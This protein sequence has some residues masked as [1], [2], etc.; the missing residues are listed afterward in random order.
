[1]KQLTELHLGSSMEKSDGDNNI[2]TVDRFKALLYILKNMP[3]LT[4]NYHM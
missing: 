2:F 4:C 1:M 3:K